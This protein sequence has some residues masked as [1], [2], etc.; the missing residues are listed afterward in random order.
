MITYSISPKSIYGL[1]KSEWTKINGDFTW[2][3][4]ISDYTSAVVLLPYEIKKLNNSS[5]K[6][7]EDYQEF[8]IGSQTYTIKS[9]F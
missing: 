3:I 4:T 1:I 2:N 7:I 9:S 8:N 5:I 6:K